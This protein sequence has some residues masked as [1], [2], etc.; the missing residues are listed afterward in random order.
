MT[1]PKNFSLPK[2]TRLYAAV[3]VQVSLSLVFQILH[4]PVPVFGIR[5]DTAETEVCWGY[6]ISLKGSQSVGQA[7]WEKRLDK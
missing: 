6:H 3:K 4:N 7:Y 2:A 1:T 5:R